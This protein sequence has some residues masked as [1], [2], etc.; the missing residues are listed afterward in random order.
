MLCHHK[1]MAEQVAVAAVGHW[2]I[3]HPQPNVAFLLTHDAAFPGWIVL[4]M[5]VAS[6]ARWMLSVWWSLDRVFAQIAAY[7]CEVRSNRLGYRSDRGSLF[8]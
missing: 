4:A 6:H 3:R 8:S 2:M 1:A 7:G 5:R